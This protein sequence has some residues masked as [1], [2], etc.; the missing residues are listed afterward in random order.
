[1]DTR[2]GND[3]LTGVHHMLHLFAPADAPLGGPD[4]GDPEPRRRGTGRSDRLP[5]ALLE[6][7]TPGGAIRR[8]SH[9]GTGGLL[10]AAVGGTAGL[11][12]AIAGSGAPVPWG[13]AAACVAGASRDRASRDRA[14]RDRASRGGAAD[15]AVAVIGGGGL[16]AAWAAIGLNR[17]LLIRPRSERDRLWTLERCLRCPGLAA[18]VAAL[19][20]GL[21]PVAARRLALAAELGIA[22]GGG[23]GLLLRPAAA[24]REPS[25][26]DVRLEV[27]T[28]PG[29]GVREQDTLRPR[30]RVRTLR[31]RGTFRRDDSVDDVVLELTDDARLVPVA[32][33]LAGAANPPR[34]GDRRGERDRRTRR[35]EFARAG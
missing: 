3:T 26:A 15:G 21:D 33:G 10:P 5:E 23:G 1:M 29:P 13:F 14:S 12:E 34:S 18:T 25:W 30:W 9:G 2:R 4:P 7:L 17:V 31:R 35:R 8:E 11:V 19:R 28:A 27:L 6:R 20:A 16:P 24:A 22:A 32:A